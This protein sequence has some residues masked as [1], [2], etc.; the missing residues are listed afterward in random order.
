MHTYEIDESAGT[1][2]RDGA[3]WCDDYAATRDGRLL[4]PGGSGMLRCA[5]GSCLKWIPGQVWCPGCKHR[6][7]QE[8]L[9]ARRAELPRLRRL[10][11]ELRLAYSGLF[12]DEEEDV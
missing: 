12:D 6:K 2:S 3:A 11:L 7:F 4:G 5:C 10:E 1:I 8:H 9:A